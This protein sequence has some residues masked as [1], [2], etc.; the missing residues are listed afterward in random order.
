MG[1]IVVPDDE[2]DVVPRD[3]IDTDE[4][5]DLIAADDYEHE[6][7]F[8]TCI[9]ANIVAALE[10]LNDLYEMSTSLEVEPVVMNNEENENSIA[11]VDLQVNEDSMDTVEFEEVENSIATVGEEVG[12]SIATVDEEVGNSIATVGEEV[13]NSIATVGEEVGKSKRRV[14]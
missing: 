7:N 9:Q 12:N 14:S 3:G 4:H 11:T 1:E 8:A 10:V 6:D 13:G 2:S 5:N